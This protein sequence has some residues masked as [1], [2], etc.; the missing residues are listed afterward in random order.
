MPEET[1]HH[2]TLR[3][4]RDYRFVASFDDVTGMAPVRFDE[5]PPLGDGSAPC[6]SDMLGAAVANCLSAS[7]AFCLRRARIEVKGIEARVATR[8]GRNERGRLR[9]R[10]I[11]VDLMYDVVDPEGRRARC[12][13]IFED[14]C[15]VTG[16]IRQGLPVNVSV[17]SAEGQPSV[18]SCE[19]TA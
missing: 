5:P 8:V 7:L 6:A 12:E 14:F 4:E 16:S 3:L 1:V 11:D 9:I 19:S 18:S 13:Q 10:G 2:V 15:T 17:R